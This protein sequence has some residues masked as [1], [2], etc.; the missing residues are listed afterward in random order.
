M[1]SVVVVGRNDNHGYNLGKRVANSLNSIS[2]RLSPGDE[3]IFVDWNTPR[4]FPPM[5]VAIIDDLTVETKS[6]L[7]ILTVS[8]ETHNRVKG[9][10]TKKILEPIARNVGIKNAKSDNKWILSTNTDII[11]VGNQDLKFKHLIADLDERLWQSFRYEIPEYIWERFDKRDPI[12]TNKYMQTAEGVLPLRLNLSTHP[13]E[14]DPLKFADAIGD[15]QLAPRKMWELIKGF[16]EDMLLGWHV[17]SRAAVQMINKT[18]KVSK[19]LPTTA[20]IETYHQNHLRSLTH[21]H[22]GGTMNGSELIALEY[23]NK[24]SWGLSNFQITEFQLDPEF[25]FSGSN[26]LPLTIDVENINIQEQSKSL[27]Y[28]L[29][30]LLIFMGDELN[31]LQS[32]NTISAVTANFEL[33]D[34]LN[35]IAKH[36]GF[37]VRAVSLDNIDTESMNSD[38]IIL[39]FGL[40]KG[41]NGKENLLENIFQINDGVGHI[42]KFI[43]PGSRVAL[44]RSQNWAIRTLTSKYFSLPLFNNYSSFL[45]GYRR[46]TDLKF[47][48]LKI[49]FLKACIRWEF[50]QAISRSSPGVYI[51][52][53]FKKNIPR[54]VRTLL[55][56]KVLKNN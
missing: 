41:I 13:I 26:K 8:P 48:Y 2:M 36:K 15:F 43:G 52:L 3:L 27:E 49:E 38:L 14:G 20:G 11:F 34:A 54:I 37:L 50:G 9:E 25:L 21:F 22:D 10:S 5:P 6:F 46:E 44:I 24:E 7:R 45:S 33:I 1:L 35:E 19:V 29:P 23:L 56:Q 51:Y 31:T 39:D 28:N 47:S 18:N 53:K 40:L 42:S 32:G 17:D 30:R 55:K 4:P 16:P 12:G